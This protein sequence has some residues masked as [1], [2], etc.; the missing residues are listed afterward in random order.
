LVLVDD[1]SHE[2]YA[3]ENIYYPYRIK[4]VEYKTNINSNIS[5]SGEIM[6]GTSSLTPKSF[7]NI[8][9]NNILNLFI[10]SKGHHEQMI[11][12]ENTHVGI[13][14]NESGDNCVIVFGIKERKSL[15]DNINNNKF[16]SINNYESRED[17]KAHKIYVSILKYYEFLSGNK[18]T[19]VPQNIINEC[20]YEILNKNDLKGKKCLIIIPLNDKLNLS[21]LYHYMTT[22]RIRQI[23]TDKSN[24][25]KKRYLVVWSTNHS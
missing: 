16:T 10:S 14:I 6:V 19:E 8:T 2:N 11:D 1:I 23:F 4:L 21:K 15:F 18:A 22:Y 7:I 3:F 20:Y 17:F 9:N 25:N 24:S 12:K 5:P 13:Y